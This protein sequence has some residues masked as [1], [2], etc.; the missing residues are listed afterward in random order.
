MTGW[1]NP[2]HNVQVLR[3]ADGR[4]SPADPVALRTAL[5]ELLVTLPALQGKDRL[6]GALMAGRWMCWT[7]EAK[8]SQSWLTEAMHLAEASLDARAAFAARLQLAEARRL[9]G[10][11][12][13]AS[14][15]FASLLDEADTNPLHFGQRADV[16]FLAGLHAASNGAYPD[17]HAFLERAVALC[18]ESENNDL[19]PHAEAAFSKLAVAKEAAPL[20]E[21]D[22]AVVD[23]V[24]HNRAGW[25]RWAR[26]GSP[27]SQPA[28]EASFAEARVGR[29]RLILTPNKAVPA[30]WLGPLAGKAVLGLASGGG[31]Q[32][33]LFAAA[34]AQVTS[35]D[36]SDA[37][38][39]RDRLVAKGAGLYLDTVQGDMAD[40][41]A[42]ADNTFDLV[43]HPVSNVF[44]PNVLPVWRE[45]YRV[46]RPGGALLSGMMNPAFFLFDHQDLENGGELVVRF[47]TPYS[48]LEQLPPERL[49]EVL[50]A[51]EVVEYGHSLE[52]LL[53]GQLA[54]GL[55]LTGLYED[56]WSDEASPLNRSFPIFL[57]TRSVKST[58]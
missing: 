42:L 38:L 35:Y 32:M 37:Q 51:G 57:A 7:G 30:A 29:P 50:R 12:A 33:P 16:A 41:S 40:L 19:L 46:L 22:T 34:G 58:T 28:D 56:D 10:D 31:Q 54:A 4:Q 8:A 17:A 49:A 48:D 23:A 11:A 25:N 5:Q 36:L 26:S 43:F 53:G 15:L 3:G 52:D 27:W 24:A 44:A 20:A 2:A 18:G 14:E 9:C 13:K 45:V 1:H 21:P 6:R 47:R 55:H 39:N